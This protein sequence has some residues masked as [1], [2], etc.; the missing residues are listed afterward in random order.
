MTSLVFAGLYFGFIGSGSRYVQGIVY[1]R[2]SFT[3]PTHYTE[4]DDGSDRAF[5][6]EQEGRVVVIDKG[7]VQDKTVAI[8]L[9]EVRDFYKDWEGGLLGLEF[10]PQFSIDNYI[11]LFYTIND[12]SRHSSVDDCE[13]CIN[14]TISRF[15]MDSTNT[16]KIDPTSEMVLLEI[17]QFRS[18]HRGGM[19]S[20]GPDG[21]LYVNIGDALTGQSQLLS[22]FYG[23]ILRIDVSS[24]SNGKNY[25][26][27][28]DNPYAGNTDGYKEE[29]YAYGFRNPWRSSFDSLTGDLWVGDVGNFT[30]EEVN[31][32]ESGK[33][34]GWPFKEGHDCVKTQ[35]NC[36]GDFAEAILAYPHELDTET[37][38]IEK[39]FG[40]SDDLDLPNG[41][42]VI[43]GHVYRGSNFPEL[44]G[45]YVFA[46]YTGS[47]WAL[48]FNGAS[49][50]LNSIE[51][52]T[53]FPDS[54]SSIGKTIDGELRFLGHTLGYVYKIEYL[55][56]F[57]V[58]LIVFLLVTISIATIVA[59]LWV[60]L[61]FKRNNETFDFKTNLRPIFKRT[62]LLFVLILI[63]IGLSFLL[64]LIYKLIF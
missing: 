7:N 57:I 35:P 51:F 15:T 12:T 54:I 49:K 10:S 38:F 14:S 60:W 27:P 52:V 45:K 28:A 50:E 2:N 23:K 32:V 6:L 36:S 55:T 30:S 19:L 5:I 62:A 4:P 37:S 31:V 44:V 18:N 17:P 64:E 9:K 16:N 41:V 58:T 48:D 47:V 56:N 33:N 29:I 46:D 34:Y 1:S 11:Y 26:I 3:F 20:F 21:M 22:V 25:T 8:D 43:G 61:K 24:P 53:R 59:T 13:T 39:L 40:L 63:L 42:S